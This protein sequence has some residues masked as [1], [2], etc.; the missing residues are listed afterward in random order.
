MIDKNISDL[1]F[2]KW[3]IGVIFFLIFIFI[4]NYLGFAYTL[5]DNDAS[6]ITSLIFIIFIYFS[7][8]VGIE[9]FYLR[10][11]Y[12]HVKNL[13]SMILKG[14][15]SD[16]NSI[17]KIFQYSKNNDDQS[18]FFYVTSNTDSDSAKENFEYSLTSKLNT[19]WLVADGLL[20][21]GLIGTVIGFIIM[22]SA[23]TEID[24]FDFTMMKEMLQNMSRGMEV[25]LYTTLSG[26]VSSILLTIQ[27][28]YLEHYTYKIFYITNNCLSHF[29]SEL[30]DINQND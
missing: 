7:G 15:K 13:L 17:L 23:I 29:S 27:Y 26:L 5:I 20:K 28:S 21:L 30:V 18:I 2:I 9:L 4:L 1:I 11:R 19:G 12:L 25:A 16:I 3:F 8:K 22:L 14:S 10:T 24:G 6:Y